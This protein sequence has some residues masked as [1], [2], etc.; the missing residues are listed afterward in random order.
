M[1]EIGTEMIRAEDITF[2]YIRRDAEGNVL[3]IETALNH[4][5]LHIKKG[6]FVAILGH[7]G[8]GKSTFAKHVNAIFSPGE[9]SMYVDGKDTSDLSKLYEIRQKAGMV[10]QNPDNQII[11]TVVDED[12]AFGPENLG[13]PTGKIRERVEQALKSVHMWHRRKDSP[14]KLSGGQKQRVAIA[15]IMAMEPECIV[16][17]EPTAMLDPGGR[18]DVIDTVRRL[19]REKNITILLIT[20]NM[21]ET[22]EADRVVVMDHGEVKLCGTP[23]EVFS[24]VE[25]LTK[26]GLEVPF[27][28][29]I[30]HELRMAGIPVNASVLREEELVAE[31]EQLAK[32]WKLDKDV[33]RQRQKSS[34][35]GVAKPKRYEAPA[36]AELVGQSSLILDHV[37]YIY[38]PGTLYEKAAIRDVNLTFTKGEFVGIVGHTGS[39][40][41]T[42]IQ[43]LNG[44]LKPTSGTVYY[45]G[46]DITTKDFS[47]KKLRSKVGLS[48]QYPEHQLFENTVYE[49][50][51]FGPK[52]LGWEELKI[53]QKSYDAIK[54]VGLPDDCYDMSPFQL[55]GGQK[56]RVAIA[57]VLAMDPDYLVL[58]EPTAGLDPKG[59][60]EILG[61]IQRICQERG[62]TV[63]LVSHSMED[64][65][66]YVDRVI[67][68]NDGAIVYNDVPARVF[69]HSQELSQMGLAVPK[70]SDLMHHL[71]EKGFPAYPYLIQEED[72]VDVIKNWF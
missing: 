53:E 14:N 51:A 8:S 63:I 18:K 58:D 36:P 24:H 49:D 59:R 23:V 16:L 13:V 5:N 47:L 56:R 7:N 17:D 69:A 28:T 71:Q 15:G 43:H 42:L 21:D 26:M 41:S 44:L 66:K 37:N 35:K 39:G 1:I 38:N 33:L 45:C 70:V 60:D 29:R 67:V 48:F 2:E 32:E 54:M 34:E 25:E 50:V 27:A 3:E 6:E 52:N 22:I 61:Q 62:I 68:V 72:A 40:K 64:I 20:H 10:F 46:E 4:V 31:L 55:S 9:G 12:V 65:A 30:A 19:N 57:G 11:A